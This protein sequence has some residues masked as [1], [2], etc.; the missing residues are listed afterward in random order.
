M[1]TLALEAGDIDYADLLS[2]VKYFKTNMYI[3]VIAI[4]KNKKNE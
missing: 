1:L 3:I 4:R 2:L